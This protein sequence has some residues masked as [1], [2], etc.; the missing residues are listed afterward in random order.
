MGKKIIE[1]CN[2]SKPVQLDKQKPM[3]YKISSLSYAIRKHT[4]T[5]WLCREVAENVK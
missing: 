5:K 4:R 1:K 2:L 3:K